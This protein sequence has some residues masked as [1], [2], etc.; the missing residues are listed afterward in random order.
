MP[1][2]TV[3]G[4]DGHRLEVNSVRRG[5]LSPAGK[6]V[7]VDEGW[8]T[9]AAFALDDSPHRDED[10]YINRIDNDPIDLT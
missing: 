3:M 7:P 6:L 2:V 5:L 1:N 10:R 9:F 8:A 4:L